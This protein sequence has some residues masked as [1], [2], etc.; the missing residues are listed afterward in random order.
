M[1][2]AECNAAR[3]K[4]LQWLLLSSGHCAGGGSAQC[5][6]A[7]SAAYPRWLLTLESL[8][9]FHLSFNFITLPVCPC[10]LSALFSLS[11]PLPCWLIFLTA[12]PALSLQ[13]GRQM[14]CVCNL[15]WEQH[16]LDG[17]MQQQ[18]ESSN[19]HSKW[20]QHKRNLMFLTSIWFCC[21]SLA[22]QQ[23]VAK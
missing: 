14:T 23:S 21:V 18:K 4:A 2:V 13:S 1:L 10:L 7:Y 16:L 8:I 12:A 20:N 17:S 22:W 3:C 15:R 11:L 5:W 6:T 9:F 19:S